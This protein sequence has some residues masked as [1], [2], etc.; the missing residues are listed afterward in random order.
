MFPTTN[1]FIRQKNLG[2]IQFSEEAVSER[3]VVVRILMP[4][5]KS[6]DDIVRQLKQNY[7]ES[8]DIGYIEKM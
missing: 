3:S 5:H 6:T 4:S 2:V 7:A 1:A 8:I